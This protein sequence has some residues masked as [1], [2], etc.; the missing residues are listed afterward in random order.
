MRAST[1]NP[2][3]P[4]HASPPTAAGSGES[5]SLVRAMTAVLARWRPQSTAEALRMLRQGYPDAPLAMRIAAMSAG[6][7]HRPR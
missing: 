2:Y 5:E 1:D 6:A 4:F 3:L 7:V